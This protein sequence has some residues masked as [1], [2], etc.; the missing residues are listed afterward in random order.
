MIKAKAYRIA[1]AIGSVVALIE[2]IGAPVKIKG[3]P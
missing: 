1:I 2:A 3:W